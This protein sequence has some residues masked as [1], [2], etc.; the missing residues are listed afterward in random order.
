M[1]KHIILTKYCE[2]GSSL[3][4]IYDSIL[5]KKKFQSVYSHALN[6]IIDFCI[7]FNLPPAR[8]VAQYLVDSSHQAGNLD[9]RLDCLSFVFKKYRNCIIANYNHIKSNQ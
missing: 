1:I 7:S 6:I 5:G 2:N 8:Y 4:D 9:S 3:F